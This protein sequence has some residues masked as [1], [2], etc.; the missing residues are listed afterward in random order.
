MSGI[1]KS[2]QITLQPATTE[3]RSFKRLFS[4]LTSLDEIK[5]NFVFYS[6]VVYYLIADKLLQHA[7]TDIFSEG[8][9]EM[10]GEHPLVIT[11]LSHDVFRPAEGLLLSPEH[12][13]MQRTIYA[14]DRN[15]WNAWTDIQTAATGMT[16]ID[17][18]TN[19]FCYLSNKAATISCPFERYKDETIEVN[20]FQCFGTRINWLFSTVTD[21]ANRQVLQLTACEPVKEFVEVGNKILSLFA[22]ASTDQA[23][24]GVGGVLQSHEDN[25]R[26]QTMLRIQK[27]NKLAEKLQ[28]KPL[29]ESSLSVKDKEEI[30]QLI[31]SY[32]QHYGLLDNNA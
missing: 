28:S 23:I 5:S 25:L 18:S 9:R 22:A 32:K 7:S 11:D 20:V 21:D 4:S 6:P 26:E 8:L 17:R 15:A 19:S 31:Y 29:A 2:S 13:A 12:K 16:V 1:I 3:T 30:E 10:T 14:S 27:E 24:T